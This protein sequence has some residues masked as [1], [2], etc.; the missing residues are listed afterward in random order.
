MLIAGR[1]INQPGE[2]FIIAEAGVNH[3]GDPGMAREL[4]EAAA[5]SGANAVKF[6]TFQPKLL[7]SGS[8]RRAEYQEAAEG[9]DETQQQMLERLV[10]P[11][12]VLAE[13]RVL[14]TKLG[15]ALMSTPFDEQSADHLRDIGVPAI[16]ISSG[17]LTNYPL[18]ARVATYGLP[19][20]MSTGMSTVAEI[21]LAVQT[22]LRNGC[23]D[24]ALLHCLSSYPA[25]IEESNLLAMV[26]LR[27]MFGLPVGY[28]DHTMGHHL[29]VGAVAL[30]AEIIEKHVT[31]DRK[32]K[33]PDHS[34]S[35]EPAELAELVSQ[36]R[37][38]AK[39]LGDGH[40]NVMPCEENTR[41]AAR[42]SITA[43]CDIPD[44]AVLT[45]DMLTLRR[46]GTGI[47][48]V[49]LENVIG[50]RVHRAIGADETLTWEDI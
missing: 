41:A 28:S 10:L 34:A 42:R 32:L 22:L 4:V 15:I 23:Q 19:V 25:P 26:T 13:L 20:I 21:D 37:A 6:Q 43:A 45:L 33:G 29:S 40:K 1:V 3:N 12:E 7:V 38:M 31:L 47:H 44:G 49:E 24:I 14:A 8:A 30:G 35:I 50:R 16:K 27:Q 2:V 46:P 11:L 39:A 48:P 18:L 9:G 36:C 5:A 17:E